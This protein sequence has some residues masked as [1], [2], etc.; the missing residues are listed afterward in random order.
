MQTRSRYGGVGGGLP[1]FN[2]EAWGVTHRSTSLLL[3]AHGVHDIIATFL[4][5]VKPHE[6]GAGF[7]T[8]LFPLPLPALK[9]RGNE[10]VAAVALPRHSGHTLVYNLE[11]GAC[12][13][14]ERLVRSPEIGETALV[15]S[16][17]IV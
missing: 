17:P 13:R 2:L 3:W 8:S 11:W 16:W 12:R 7:L 15:F 4:L 1:S 9:K 5:P 6:I 14:S 10:R